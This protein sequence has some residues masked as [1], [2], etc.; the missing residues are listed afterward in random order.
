MVQE[1]QAHRYRGVLCNFCRKPIPLPE[2]VSRLEVLTSGDA[3]SDAGATNLEIVE[4]SFHIR[5]RV[6]EKESSYRTSD[7]IEVEGTPLLRNFRARAEAGFLQSPAG[8]AKAA[9]G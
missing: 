7:A 3:S 2:I 8:L 5:C 1:K 6:C 9:N 4:R